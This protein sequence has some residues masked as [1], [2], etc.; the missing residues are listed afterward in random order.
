MLDCRDRR[1]SRSPW[2]DVEPVGRRKE[3]SD[4]KSKGE[5]KGER[6]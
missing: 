6:R 2:R 4:R 1:N 5:G 3:D